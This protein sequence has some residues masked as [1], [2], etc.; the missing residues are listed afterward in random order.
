MVVGCPLA[1]GPAGG[2]EFAGRVGHLRRGM[3]HH[4]A[5][6]KLKD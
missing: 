5:A 3:V 4:A 6:E 2:S 1:D